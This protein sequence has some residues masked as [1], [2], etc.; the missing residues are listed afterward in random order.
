MEKVEFVFAKS[1]S[2]SCKREEINKREK[3]KDPNSEREREIE[4]DIERER[5]KDRER[6]IEREV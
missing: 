2:C 4:R 5:E 1:S 6:R 3:W